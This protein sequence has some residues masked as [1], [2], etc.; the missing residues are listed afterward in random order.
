[1]KQYRRSIQQSLTTLDCDCEHQKDTL[2]EPAARCR[3]EERQREKRSLRLR[4]EGLAYWATSR[5]MDASITAVAVA[6]IV[7]SQDRS[8]RFRCAA[9]TRM[10]KTTRAAVSCTCLAPDW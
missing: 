3:S 4:A 1:M 10:S 6:Q 8:T 2:N 5:R 7:V 9:R